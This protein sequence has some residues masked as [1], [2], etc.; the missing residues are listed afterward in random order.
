MVGCFVLLKQIRSREKMSQRR[1][2]RRNEPIAI[3]S[4][5]VFGF[6]FLM[7]FVMM[8]VVMVMMMFLLLSVAFV[9]IR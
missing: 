3:Q 7:G 4:D 9:V 1:A 5:V 6:V 8:M 2:D